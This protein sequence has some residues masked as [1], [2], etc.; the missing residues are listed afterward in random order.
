MIFKLLIELI[1]FFPWVLAVGLDAVFSAMPAIP[2]A[3]FSGIS[4]V[5][6]YVGFAI[7]LLGADAAKLIRDTALVLE[8]L[9]PMMF[10]WTAS[11]R[12]IGKLKGFL[13]LRQSANP[14]I[15]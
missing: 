11:A 13:A 3:I 2:D 8:W 9:V 1:C 7:S 5:A 15:P 4:G 12:L 10:L 6:E 14:P